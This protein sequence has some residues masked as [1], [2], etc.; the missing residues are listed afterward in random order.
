MDLTAVFDIGKTHKKFLLFDENLE[1]VVEDSI[2]IDEIEDEDGFPCDDLN[3]ISEWIK[4]KVDTDA[5][6]QKLNFTTYG[7][8]LVHLD[9]NRKPITPLYNYL[10]PIPPEVQFEFYEKYGPADKF[11]EETSSP[12]LGML[13]SGL[14]LFWL[15]KAKPK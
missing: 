13:N 12:N 3:A 1:T 9:K 8:S 5:K 6:I 7:A 15:K 11:A 2:K 4:T 10:K 14:Q